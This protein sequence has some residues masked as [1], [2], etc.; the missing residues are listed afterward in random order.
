MFDLIIRNGHLMDPRCNLDKQADIGIKGRHIVDI[1]NLE[2]KECLQSVDA[3]G[4]L[5]VPGLID[6]HAHAA[7]GIS[8]FSMPADLV[9][10]PSGVT[11]MVD[12]GSTGVTDFEAFY[13]RNII[14]SIM[15]V[16]SFL[17]VASE[18]QRTHLKY[19]N[20]DPARYDLE[21]IKMLCETYKDNIIGLK[22]RQS[23]DIVGELG[24]KPLEGALLL[25]EEV[26]L[27]LSVHATD[28]PGDIRDTLSLLRPGDIF[29]HM[30]HQKGVLSPGL[31]APYPFLPCITSGISP[32]PAHSDSL[33]S[34]PIHRIFHAPRSLPILYHLAECPDRR[35]SHNWH[36]Y[37]TF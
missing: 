16:K 37:N 36:S 35:Y 26:G 23:R 32:Y 14:T 12:A 10:I 2:G 3:K 7:Y 22:L 8:D 4:C 30:Y 5:V 19:E 9:Q 6:F 28:S 20:P 11:S 1:G 13:H 25:G 18:G 33:A 29:C 27:R 21:K 31:P 17:H 34:V 15:T 24:L